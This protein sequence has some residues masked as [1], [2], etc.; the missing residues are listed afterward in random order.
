MKTQR[1]IQH[2]GSRS[3]LASALDIKPSAVS[4]WGDV[5]PIRR[6]YEL[7]ILTGG[8][9]KARRSRNLKPAA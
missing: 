1:A 5:V 4:Q 6:Q 8:K 9:L 7:E 3:A 2:F